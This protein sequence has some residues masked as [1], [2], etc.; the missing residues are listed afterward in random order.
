M[1]NQETF[2]NLMKNI[3]W[4][5]WEKEKGEDDEHTEY[6]DLCDVLICKLYWLKDKINELDLSLAHSDTINE[7][8]TLLSL[9][10]EEKIKRIL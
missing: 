10:N 6:F 7:V 3:N 5:N 9:L 2:D 1:N 8:Q 4:E